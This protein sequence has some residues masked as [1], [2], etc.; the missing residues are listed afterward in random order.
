MMMLYLLHVLGYSVLMDLIEKQSYT[1]CTFY[2]RISV[3]YQV[4]CHQQTT[5]V[6]MTTI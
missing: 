2:N 3:K 4:F 6:T 5:G 1:F